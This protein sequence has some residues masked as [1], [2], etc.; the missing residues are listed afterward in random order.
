MLRF[1]VYE[2]ARPAREMALRN[3]YLLGPDGNA[4][5]AEIAFEDGCIVC[6]KREPGVAALCLLRPA[7][8]CG[9]LTLQTCVLPERDEPYLLNLELA[10]HRLMLLYVKLEDWG[11]FELAVE[12]PVLERLELARRLFLAALCAAR[13]KPAD[14]ERLAADALV[15]ALDGTE[16]LALSHSEVL[17]AR[18]RGNGTLPQRPVG[19]GV[20]LD[21]TNE[22][23]R[24]GVAANF[25]FVWLPTAW[26]ELAPQEGEYRW[27]P[28][29]AWME[30]ATHNRLP[31][32][33]G[34]VLNFH[35]S[36]LPDWI[37]IWEDQ[38]EQL[39]DVLY[40]HIERVVSRYR[41]AVATW[42]VV[43]GL[44][45]NSHLSFTFD[46]LLDLTRM[47]TMLVKKLA[48][49]SQVLVELRQP[50][51]E[52]Y[53]RNPRSIPPMMYVDLLLQSAVQVDGL[54]VKLLMGQ[55]V[56]GQYTRDLMQVSHLLDQFAGLGS[57]LYL[58]LAAPS[59]PVDEAM[60]VSSNTSQP[61]DPRC[62]FWRRPWSPLVQAHWIEAMMQVAISKPFV[63]AVTWHDI[64]DHPNIELPLS[65]LVTE[66]LQPKVA[67]G[68]L[69]AWRRAVKGLPPLAAPPTTGA[70]SPPTTAPESN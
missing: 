56:D 29:D 45:V 44:H 32:V 16:E 41:G 31:V 13:S 17:L 4:I 70:E 24:G 48:P 54:S 28:L 6:R 38:Y 57:P 22:R 35:P 40:E 26:R 20:S 5:W 69:V 14:A 62:G 15:A 27:G 19:C 33:A 59:H 61:V 2:D 52:Y 37:Y 50:F 12:H 68:R 42:T 60:I 10:R 7:G 1:A 55:A 39:R 3:A 65:G 58:T 66:E 25:D 34:P 30:W 53:S 8:D 46:Q 21:Q 47:A 67:F 64:I 49:S 51:G 18:R 43:S 11:M 36:S 23:V 63:E 9:E